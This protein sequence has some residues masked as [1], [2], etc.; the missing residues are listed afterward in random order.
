MH[1]V[2]VEDD[3]L[4]SD[5][6]KRSLQLSNYPICL[7]QFE[8]GDAALPYVQQNLQSVDLFILDI[9]LP[10]TMT[11]AQLA[12]R[13]RGLG[14]P[15][16]IILTSAFGSPDPNWLR[17]NRLEYMPKPWYIRDLMTKLPTYDRHLPARAVVK[18]KAPEPE[19]SSPTGPETT[20]T[21]RNTPR[22]TGLGLPRPVQ[23]E[24]ADIVIEVDEDAT[25]PHPPSRT[26]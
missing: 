18:P 22:P 21:S 15:G 24:L 4:L 14:Y 23:D 17:A 2:H 19:V 11:G 13:I 20:G 7:E 9:C 12:E 6:L 26:K 25:L 8:D 3:K 16:Y 10:G 1:I 5:I